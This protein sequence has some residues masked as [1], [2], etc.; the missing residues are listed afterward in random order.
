MGNY[1]FLAYVMLIPVLFKSEVDLLLILF[2]I[3]EVYLMDLRWKLLNV[4]KRDCLFLHDIVPLKRC[5]I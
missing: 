4:K 1:Y 5:V 3:S 2:K